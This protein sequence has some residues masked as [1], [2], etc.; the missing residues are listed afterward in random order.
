M[1]YIL[2]TIGSLNQI[3]GMGLRYFLLLKKT[4]RQP[5]PRWITSWVD[6]MVGLWFLWSLCTFELQLNWVDSHW[7]SVNLLVGLQRPKHQICLTKMIKIQFAQFG[8]VSHRTS[9]HPEPSPYE[10]IELLARVCVY[11][12]WVFKSHWVPWQSR[13][14][15]WLTRFYFS[16]LGEETH[17]CGCSF[18]WVGICCRSGIF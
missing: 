1:E 9:K 12:L 6:F 17:P 16:R 7:L 18:S 8:L 11:G 14:G 10:V 15:S 13:T 4:R 2:S 3:N 5:A